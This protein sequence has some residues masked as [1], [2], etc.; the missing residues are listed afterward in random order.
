MADF[1]VRGPYVVPRFKGKIVTHDEEKLFWEKHKKHAKRRGCYVFGI[2]AS[3][4][5]KPGYVGKTRKTLKQ[6]VFTDRNL[7]LYNRFLADRE[8]GT[9]VI[10]FILMP[11]KQGKPNNKQIREVETYLINLGFTANPKI[12][13]KQDKV[14]P[15]WGIRGVVRGGKGKT[16]AGTGDFRKLMGIE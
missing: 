3:R 16:V 15:D 7:N 6:E 10:F 1:V 13:N 4:G 12:L 11:V 2:R 5:Y 14:V 9:P 8:K